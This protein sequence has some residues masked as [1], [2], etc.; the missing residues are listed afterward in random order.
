MLDLP[1]VLQEFWS[2]CSLSRSASLKLE[3]QAMREMSLVVVLRL[4]V[5]R[6]KKRMRR[7]GGGGIA[8]VE[9]VR[10]PCSW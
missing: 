2:P 3:F 10:N 8:I 7:C 4:G 1:F 6:K 5:D 9:T